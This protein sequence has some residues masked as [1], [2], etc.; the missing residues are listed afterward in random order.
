MQVQAYLFF[1]GNCEEAVNFYRDA[2]GAQVRMTMRYNQSPDAP[3]PGAVPPN[4][5]DKI[6]HTSFQVG[7]T[8]VMA[9]DGCGDGETSH[10]GFSLSLAVDTVAEAERY[11]NAL[12]RGGQVRMPLTKTFWS[13]GF[14]MLADR[15]GVAWMVNVVAAEMPAAAQK[16]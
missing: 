8:V 7:D 10:S 5:G 4:W 16:G 6:M 3:P 14:G 9:S 12:A 15:F 2:L 13:P 11:F 1:N